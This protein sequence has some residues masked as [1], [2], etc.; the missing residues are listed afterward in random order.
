MPIPRNTLSELDPVTFPI[1]E[2][3]VSSFIVA[4]LLANVSETE[5]MPSET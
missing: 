2:S 5:T 1:E 4:T 3:A